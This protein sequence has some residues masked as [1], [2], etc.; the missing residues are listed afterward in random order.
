MTDRPLRALA[1]AYAGGNL[2]YADY[3]AQRGKLLDTLAK[4]FSND[5]ND[6]DDTISSS[7][8]SSESSSEEPPSSS[9]PEYRNRTIFSMTILILGLVGTMAFSTFYRQ[10]KDPVFVSQSLPHHLINL[11]PS[12]ESS[13]QETAPLAA[14]PTPP[15][16]TVLQAAAVRSEI[17]STP[18]TTNPQPIIPF[19]ATPPITPISSTVAVSQTAIPQTG[20]IPQMTIPHAQIVQPAENVT[21]GESNSYVISN[22]IMKKK[23]NFSSS[24]PKKKHNDAKTSN[25]SS[26]NKNKSSGNHH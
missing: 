13:F 22:A 20:I 4:E 7:V 18:Q 12:L 5:G 6:S 24:I 11:A 1:Q 10:S 17:V 26:K 19:E 15:M 25:S 8:A 3:R 14:I 21:P 2:D 16:E 23:L 9:K